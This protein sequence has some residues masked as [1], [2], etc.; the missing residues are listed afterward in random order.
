MWIKFIIN[1]QI[2][3]YQAIF[4]FSICCY[5]KSEQQFFIS[6]N[7]SKCTTLCQS[8]KCFVFGTL[9]VREQFVSMSPV[10]IELARLTSDKKVLNHLSMTRTKASYKMRH[11][12]AKTFFKEMSRNLK[13]RKFSLNIDEATSSYF[14]SVLSILAIYFR[15]DASKVIV[16]HL[17]TVCVTRVNTQTLF[18]EMVKLFQQVNILGII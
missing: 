9:S 17:G 13:S 2:L 6:T 7:A 8:Y 18:D 14:K 10:L 4:F 12:L 3:Q 16:E 15:P 5:I 11:G 1:Y